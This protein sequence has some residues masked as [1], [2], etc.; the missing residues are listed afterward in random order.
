MCLTQA[1]QYSKQIDSALAPYIEKWGDDAREILEHLLQ[2]LEAGEATLELRK[3][4]GV[5]RL[6]RVLLLDVFYH[7]TETGQLY[8]LKEDRQVYDATRKVVRRD[9]ECSVSEKLLDRE[10]TEKEGIPRALWEEL[11]IS[12]SVYSERN[13]EMKEVRESSSYPFL[14]TQSRN[15]RYRVLLLEPTQYQP[16]GYI[17]HRDGV[18]T[19]FVWVPYEPTELNLG[20]LKGSGNAK[21][22]L[23]VFILPKKKS[24]PQRSAWKDDFGKIASC[25]ALVGQTS[26]G[27]PVVCCRCTT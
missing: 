23:P 7:N 15:I 12:G 22:S 11:G 10:R 14:L 6:I 19:Y 8:Y 18:T 21:Q 27:T 3:N 5:R 16:E 26:R 4:G 1:E 25:S 17:E 2:E 20:S 9:K 13:D 24:R